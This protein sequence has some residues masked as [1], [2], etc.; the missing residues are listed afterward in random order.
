MLLATIDGTADEKLT[1]FALRLALSGHVGI[2]REN[3]PD[4]LTEAEA[5][6]TP[7]QKKAMPQKTSKTPVALPKPKTKAKK[8]KTAKKQIAA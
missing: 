3:E 2:P 6:F 1:R 8:Q 5:V 7:Q 4:F